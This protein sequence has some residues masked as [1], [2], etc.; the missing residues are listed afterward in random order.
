MLFPCSPEESYS[1]A[2][3]AFDLAERFQTPVF[4]LSDLDLGMNTWM[5][6]KFEYPTKPIDRGKVL[7]EETLE[8]IGRFGRYRDVD[9]DGIPYRSI[10]GSSGP[11][12]FC[13][14][15]GHNEWGQYSE[16]SDDYAKNVD[17]LARKFDT[18]RNWM[19]APEVEINRRAGIGIIAYGT[20]HWAVI[21]GRDQLLEEA[22]LQTSYYRLRAYPFRS[23]LA[24]FIERHDRVYVVEQNR[25]AQMASLMRLELQA[26]LT[27]RLRS[28][29]YYA[30]LPIDG[31]TISDDILVQEGYRA[32][33]SVA[34]GRIPHEAGVGGE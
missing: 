28:V 9:G 3:D 20:S 25:D 29:L 33:Y 8:K 21:E 30:G 10:P 18:A 11:A 5:S 7:D 15:S 4:V 27:G 32:E 34:D 24:S 2:V 23:G 17:R 1:M 14:G 13:R 12:Y 26:E 16:R 19:P 22:D 6:P 31:R